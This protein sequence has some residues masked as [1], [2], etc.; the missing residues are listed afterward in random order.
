MVKLTRE[1][2]QK[3]IKCAEWQRFRVDLKGRTTEDKLVQLK[4]YL[5]FEYCCTAETRRVQVYNYLNALSRG[6]QIK[7]VVDGDLERGEVKVQR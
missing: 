3:A 1:A 4:A 7:P 5:Q 2:I 6:G